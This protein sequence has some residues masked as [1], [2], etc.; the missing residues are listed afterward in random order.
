MTFGTSQTPQNDSTSPAAI[1]D[2]LLLLLLLLAVGQQ[3]EPT[4][5]ITSV[6]LLQ[7]GEVIWGAL[8]RENTSKQHLMKSTSI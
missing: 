2:L 8:E 7:T 5:G 1:C 6:S 4:L 3:S